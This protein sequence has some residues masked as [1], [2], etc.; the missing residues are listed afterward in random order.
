MKFCL[1]LLL[2]CGC[3]SGPWGR[4]VRFQEVPPSTPGAIEGWDEDHGT[5]FWF[6]VE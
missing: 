4:D 1:A 6:L 2:L 5:N 3:A